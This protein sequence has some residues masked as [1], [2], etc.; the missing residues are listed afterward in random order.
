M[1]AHTWLKKGNQVIGTALW[2]YM[3][4]RFIYS[5]NKYFCTLIIGQ[6]VCLGNTH[7]KV[8]SPCGA[9]SLGK[10]GELVNTRTYMCSG[11]LLTL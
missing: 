11:S 3:G 8:L 5:F 10:T 4:S 1:R 7:R 9:Y 6:S 2:S